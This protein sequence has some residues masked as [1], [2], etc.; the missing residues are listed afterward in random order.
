MKITVRVLA[1]L[2]LLFFVW[3]LIADRVTPYTSN[4]RV[5]AIVIDVVPEVSGYVSALAVSNGQVVEA[6]ALLARIDPHPF[7][8]GGGSRPGQPADGDSEC[9]RQFLPGRECA[10]QRD[11]GAG[12]SRERQVA[13]RA[14]L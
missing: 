1:S 3:Y 4:A 5:K 13:E 14:D 6:G 2:A 12:Q 11:H 7:Q 9:R 10:G 8:L